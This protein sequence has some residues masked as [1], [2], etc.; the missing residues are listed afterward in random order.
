M[1]CSKKPEATAAP[2]AKATEA[3][4]TP[5]PAADTTAAPDTKASGEKVKLTVYSTI[6]ELPNQ[7]VMKGIAADFTEENPNI[8]VDFQFPGSEYENI[9]KVKMA[10]NDLPDVFDT[11]GWAVIRYG[12]YLAD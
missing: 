12:K 11:H 5:A 6:G 9:L 10:A 1:G 2:D 4:A 3:A 7:A 8:E